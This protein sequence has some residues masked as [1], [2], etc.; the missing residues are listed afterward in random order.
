M[1][2]PRDNPW[3]QRVYLSDI[4]ALYETEAEKSLN[5]DYRYTEDLT[6]KS[7]LRYHVSNF[8]K[9]FE[10]EIQLRAVK[11]HWQVNDSDDNNDG[12]GILNWIYNTWNS[13][14]GSEPRHDTPRSLKRK[15]VRE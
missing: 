15:L 7:R 6:H 5:G 4:Q 14:R 12:S 11:Y 2:E 8:N 13:H 1:G 3:D 10:S 9:E